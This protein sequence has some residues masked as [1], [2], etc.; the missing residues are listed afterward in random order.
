MALAHGSG[1]RY[2]YFADLT[3]GWTIVLFAQRRTRLLQAISVVLLCVMSLGI[4]LRWEH[5]AFRD[6]HWAEYAK[7]F[8][9]APAGTVDTIRES[10]PGWN[11]VLI[12][13]TSR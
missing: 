5:P 2:W 8:E 12:K 7:S 6:A 11:L 4:A 13:H 3:V 10:T 1:A 9:S